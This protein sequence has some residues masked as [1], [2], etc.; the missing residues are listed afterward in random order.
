[1][2][3][4]LIEAAIEVEV[5]HH[6]AGTAGQAEIDIRRTT[7]T[8]MADCMMMYKF[9]IKNVAVENG[10]TATFMPKP[11]Y[12]DN[13]SGMH[14]HQSL[15]KEGNP[16]F[17]DEEGYALTSEMCRYYVGGLQAH[18]PAL[19]ALCPPTTNSYRRLVPGF[20]VPVSRV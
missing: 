20:E 10:M 19:L 11:I 16:L 15:W 14:T 18:D 4:R 12:G 1:M 13:G 17:F 6:E 2:V 5:H 9:I 8:K 3:L 7:L